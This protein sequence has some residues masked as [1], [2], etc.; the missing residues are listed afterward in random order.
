[1]S[2]QPLTESPDISISSKLEGYDLRELKLTSMMILL[3]GNYLSSAYNCIVQYQHFI[4]TQS[5][6][7][8]RTMRRLKKVY[9]TAGAPVVMTV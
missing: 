8:L 1:M 7:R 9:S 4:P 6:E 5:D 3:L 2:V